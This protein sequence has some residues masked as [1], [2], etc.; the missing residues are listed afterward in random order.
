MPRPA[1]LDD[2]MPTAT[3][4]TFSELTTTDDEMEP[5]GL[6]MVESRGCCE[7]GEC[8]SPRAPV[9][10]IKREASRRARSAHRVDQWKRADSQ[11][12]QLNT[13]TEPNHENEPNDDHI[14]VIDFQDDDEI[15]MAE[16][17]VEVDVAMDSGCC[18]HVVNPDAVPA[19]VEV[20]H[21]PGRRLRNFVNAS[22]GDMDNFGEAIVQ[23]VQEDG[24]VFDSKV[25]VTETTRALHS[26]SEVCDNESP[27][28]PDGHEVLFTRGMCTVVP[29]G[30]LSKFLGGIR[31]VAKYPRRGNLWVA[32]MK[33]RAPRPRTSRQP[34][35]D[36]RT[37]NAK[38][39]RRAPERPGPKR[40]GASGFGRQGAKR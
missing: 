25:S 11:M 39:P 21:P 5:Q 26:T 29:A 34:T 31:Q 10:Q 1:T 28:C 38:A 15:L 32:K 36:A 19:G 4:N 20:A 3:T 22:G 14:G 24:K 27:A 30:A 13:V 16:Q 23:M 37:P 17:E 8:R 40:F 7:A 18:A 33:L 35:E 12:L 2:F 6:G 9:K